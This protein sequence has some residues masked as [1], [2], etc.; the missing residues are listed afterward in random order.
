[1]TKKD[2]NIDP[3]SPVAGSNDN[4]GINEFFLPSDS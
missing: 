2:S 1:M 4:F 3:Y